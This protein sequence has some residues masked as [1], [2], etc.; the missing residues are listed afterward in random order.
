[1]LPHGSEV[2]AA[3]HSRRLVISPGG[4]L[5]EVKPTAQSAFPVFSF[6]LLRAKELQET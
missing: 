4:K 2:N 3:L 1:V 5:W 6:N